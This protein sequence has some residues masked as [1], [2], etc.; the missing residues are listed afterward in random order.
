MKKKIHHFLIWKFLYVLP[1]LSLIIF[2]SSLAQEI[3][4]NFF[5]PAWGG[6]LDD[7]CVRTN[8]EITATVLF[9]RRATGR[10]LSA[11]GRRQAE[12]SPPVLSLRWLWELLL[13]WFVCW[14]RINL[15]SLYWSYNTFESLPLFYLQLQKAIVIE[16][17]IKIPIGSIALK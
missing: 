12:A 11:T 13:P 16:Q 4:R 14:F 6:V 10:P 9:G 8:F 3:S 7:M 1:L 5:D 17:I 15:K 2:F